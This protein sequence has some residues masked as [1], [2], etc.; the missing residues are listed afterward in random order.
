MFPSLTPSARSWTPG[1]PV[2]SAFVSSSGYEVRVLQ[3]AASVGQQLSL[4]FSNLLEAKGKEITD[5]YEAMRGTFG[6]FDLPA[7]VYG[8]MASYGHIKPSASSW[9][10]AGPP[11]VTYV[12]RGIV[13]VSVELV[14]VPR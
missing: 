7:E 6:L 13:S 3:G 8:G 4:V 1:Q 14:A 2:A 12:A 10:Y 11:S 5:H 9:R